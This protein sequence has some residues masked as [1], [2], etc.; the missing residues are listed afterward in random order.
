M[1]VER[2]S[3]AAPAAAPNDGQLDTVARLGAQRRKFKDAAKRLTEERD[4]IKAQLEAANK[5][6]EEAKKAD[7]AGENA[8][9]KAQ[10]REQAHRSKFDEIAKEAGANPKALNDLY[11]ASGYK[12]EDDA[13]DEGKIKAA[14]EAQ[15]KERDYLFAAPPATEQQQ[16]QL[17]AGP[18]SGQGGT[19]GNPAGAFT[20]SQEQLRNPQW[21]FEHQAELKAASDKAL[22]KPVNRVA[23]HFAIL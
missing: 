23:E 7:L 3:A 10:I 9:L 6:L 19:A 17:R 2:A 13:P 15:K 11:G 22:N 1:S 21:C 20:A 16:G 4:Q 12:A 5:S 18:A 8:R 14:I